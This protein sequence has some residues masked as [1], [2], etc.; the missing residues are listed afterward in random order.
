[1]GLTNTLGASHYITSSLIVPMVLSVNALMQENAA[2]NRNKLKL[3]RWQGTYDQLFDYYLVD[4]V[5]N[6]LNIIAALLDINVGPTALAAHDGLLQR[7]EAL[8]LARMA[9]HARE[10][11]VAIAQ[12]SNASQSSTTTTTTS[13]TSSVFA[14]M[15]RGVVD[16]TAAT[17]SMS[18]DEKMRRELDSLKLAMPREGLGELNALEFYMNGAGKQFV[19]A[20]HVALRVLVVPAGEAESERVFSSAGYFD[21]D[22]RDFAPA[23]LSKLTFIKMNTK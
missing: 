21:A 5:D 18:V 14:I 22:R 3:A 20:A 11:D 7:A 2:H 6:E 23:T 17:S 10:Q 19:H 16:N 12:T 8:T 1:M 15:R 9:Q 4:Y 13:K